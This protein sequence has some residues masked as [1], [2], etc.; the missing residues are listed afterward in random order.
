MASLLKTP[1]LLRPMFCHANTNFIYWLILH[2]FRKLNIFFINH[3]DSYYNYDITVI[4]EKNFN[5]TEINNN[6]N[7]YFNCTD[8][9]YNYD[10]NIKNL[11]GLETNAN[12]GSS[13][14]C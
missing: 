6:F 11:N 7:A 4:T 3:T 5:G 12:V 2:R 1:M 9:N 14:Y 10:I 13:Q 8:S